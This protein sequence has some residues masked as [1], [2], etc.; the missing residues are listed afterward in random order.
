MDY[1]RVRKVGEKRGV[2]GCMVTYYC[3]AERIPG[4]VKK[5]SLWLI[6]ADA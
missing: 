3:E 4:A 2:T 5:C 6:P 1:L